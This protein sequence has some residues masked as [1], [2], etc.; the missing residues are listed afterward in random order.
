M[1]RLSRRS[2]LAS[3]LPATAAV[4][5]HAQDAAYPRHAVTVIVPFA[6]AG[7]AD[8]SARLLAEKL[9]QR[10]GKPFV[11]EN[12]PGTGTVMATNYLARAR[13]DGYT[14]MIAGSTLAIEATLYRKLPYDP[15]KDFTLAALVASL[16]FVLVVNPS[17]PAHSVADLVALARTKRLSF[18]SS[19]TGS[20]G[21]VAAELFASM[22][23]IKLTHV[24]Y[25]GSALALP[26]LVRGYIQLMFTGLAPALPLIA[27]GKLRALGLT[28]KKRN[29]AAPEIA[30]LAEA[31]VPGFDATAWQGIIVPAKT[32]V[33]VSMTL[34]TEIN[35]VL[36]TADVRAQL[37][38]LGMS[39]IGIGSLAELAHFLQ[40][41][42]RHWASIIEAAGMARSV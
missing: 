13:P 17:L 37:K 36:A 18:G 34:N 24:P 9:E 42:I 2:L 5:A 15:A 40:S 3:A 21:Y 29:A 16:P 20:F 27:A 1:R 25:K 7:S 30:P 26:D 19:G 33:D 10:L 23:G 41:E 12:H 4:L 8:L 31:G 35:A 11:V 22:T 6:P 28:G 39:P 32:P 38:G 14:F